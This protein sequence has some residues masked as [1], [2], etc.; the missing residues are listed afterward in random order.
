[1]LSS[2]KLTKI[3]NLLYKLVE[4]SGFECYNKLL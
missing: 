3:V 4:L 2:P 1:M